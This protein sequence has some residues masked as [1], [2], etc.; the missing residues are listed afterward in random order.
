MAAV[1]AKCSG[2]TVVSN[3]VKLIMGLSF[4]LGTVS[5]KQIRSSLNFVD[6]QI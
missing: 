2:G 1:T 3:D 5:H 6:F 4:S